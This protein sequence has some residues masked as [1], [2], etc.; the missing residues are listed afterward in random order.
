MIA[1]YALKN[2]SFT[3]S[4]LANENKYLV[5]EASERNII[6]D[7]FVTNLLDNVFNLQTLKSGLARVHLLVV[8]TS[9]HFNLRSEQILVYITGRV[10]T[11]MSL[12]LSNA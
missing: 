2:C 11:N 5:S 10:V 3:R 12:A 6:N 8:L 1:C 4:I 9:N 7:H